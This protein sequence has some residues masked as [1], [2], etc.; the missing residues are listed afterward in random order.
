MIQY[1]ELIAVA[2]PHPTKRV[3]YGPDPLQFGHLWLPPD[4]QAPPGKRATIVF[5]HG[6][7]WES[8]YSL[9]HASHTAAALATAGYVVWLPE[10]RRLG[11]AGGGWPGTFDDA[12]AAVDF[13]RAL[14]ETEPTVDTT[15]VIAA[16]HSAGGQLALWAAARRR[17][18]SPLPLI[19]VVT[20]AAITDLAAYGAALGSCNASV[21][22]LLGGRP[23]DVR[24]RYRAVSPI[25]R[26]PIGVPMHLVH[27]ELDPIV[28]VAMTT[29]FARRATA[30]GDRADVTTITNAGH[31]DLV[32]PQT[33]AWSAVIAAFQ[34]I[35]PPRV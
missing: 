34:G 29:E 19:G 27:G 26:L 20:L 7:C 31:F 13:V 11:D 1:E 18:V 25:E 6:G 8:E 9:D 21:T 16:G 10:Y 15:R 32:A 22:P 33:P 23:S 28:P 35:S 14:G 24:E 17:D 4:P 5:I 3:A 12:G 30:A 2:A